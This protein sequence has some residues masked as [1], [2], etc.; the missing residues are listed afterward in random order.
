[1]RRKSKS[2]GRWLNKHE[3]DEYVLRA[4]K[5]GY[6]SRASYKLLEM[7]QKFGLFRPGTVV[8]DLGAAPGGWMQIA[9]K[10]CGPDGFIVGLDILDLKPIEG[11]SFIKGDFTHEKVLNELTSVLEER[12]VDLVISDMAPNLSG[13]KEIDQPITIYLAELALEFACSA[14]TSGGTLLLKSFKG[15]GI[16]Q[17]REV[18]RSK[19]KQVTNFKPE[20]SRPNSREIYIVGRG[21]KAGFD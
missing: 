18:F 17:L 15:E 5:D 8:V 4:R 20:A 3:N 12:A 16:G 11:T 21:L 10:K 13:K 7:D 6:R 19:F 2:S 1:M 9:S 14:L